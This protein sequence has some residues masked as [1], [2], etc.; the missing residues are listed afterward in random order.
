MFLMM[1]NVA[2]VDDGGKLELKF[3][4]CFFFLFFV[5]LNFSPFF[6]YLRSFFTNKNKKEEEE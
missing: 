1:A 4:S 2:I 6:L 5:L 3:F